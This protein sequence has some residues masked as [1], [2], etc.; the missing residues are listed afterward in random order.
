MECLTSHA[1]IVGNVFHGESGFDFRGF[2]VLENQSVGRWVVK[3]DGA[4]LGANCVD[5]D[6]EYSLEQA[7]KLS[8]AGKSV[9]RELN[10]TD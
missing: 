10:S 6:F 9:S 7:I 5:G 1:E 8:M 4:A 2:D 3:V